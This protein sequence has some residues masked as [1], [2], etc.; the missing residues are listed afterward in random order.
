MLKT[1]KKIWKGTYEFVLGRITGEELCLLCDDCFDKFCNVPRDEDGYITKTMFIKQQR[2]GRALSSM[3]FLSIPIACVYIPIKAFCTVE[4]KQ[5]LK[6]KN[7][8]KKRRN[9]YEEV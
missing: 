6:H 5:I 4:I 8:S 9:D 7:E 1:I 2:K 3:F